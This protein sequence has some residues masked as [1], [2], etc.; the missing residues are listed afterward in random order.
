LLVASSRPTSTDHKR[1]LSGRVKLTRKAPSGSSGNNPKS[2]M[3]N[4]KKNLG[5][6]GKKMD[7][8]L[9]KGERCRRKKQNKYTKEKI[10]NAVGL[11]ESTQ[12]RSSTWREIIVTKKDYAG[13]SSSWGKSEGDRHDVLLFGE[14]TGD[15]N[16]V[17]WLFCPS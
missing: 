2:R 12:K 16:G 14:K 8:S 1:T 11:R 4:T 17:A 6:D 9:G 10:E 3:D 7:L 15:L 5:A 13:P